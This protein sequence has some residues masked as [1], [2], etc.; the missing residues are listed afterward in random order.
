M[1]SFCDSVAGDWELYLLGTLGPEEERS[2]AAHLGAGCPDCRH[3]YAEAQMLTSSLGNLAPTRVPSQ[4]VEARLRM[5]LGPVTPMHVAPAQAEIRRASGSWGSWGARAVPW[6]IAAGLLIAF[7]TVRQERKQADERLAHVSR[8]QPANVPVPQAAKEEPNAAPAEDHSL[9]ARIADLNRRVAELKA[10]KDAAILQSQQATAQLA[11]VN[12]RISAMQAELEQAKR[13]ESEARVEASVQSTK[14]ESLTAELAAQRSAP[15]LP[16]HADSQNQQ[17]AS[18]FSSKSL[19]E[20]NLRGIDP[21][22]GSATARAFYAPGV[23]L[24]LFADS[25][26]AL[27]SAKCYQLWAIHKGSRPIESAGLLQV[28]SQGK[29]YLFA[30]DQPALNQ[31]TGLAITQE[32]NGGSV[33][34]KGRKLLFGAL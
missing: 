20:V 28:N 8:T 31:L 18:F 30:R 3:R 4:A 6:A 5:R 17:L 15:P 16:E 13:S 7:L 1:T 29:G 11:G 21:G 33:S 2:M 32:P 14:V 27:P 10:D 25:L 23:G 24:V 34:A 19:H 12:A 22:A 9:Q 26:P